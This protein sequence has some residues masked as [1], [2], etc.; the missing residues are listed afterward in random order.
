MLVN[1]KRIWEITQIICNIQEELEEKDIYLS[2]N[3]SDNF[4]Y[5]I[6][7]YIVLNIQDK[8]KWLIS[9]NKN[10][11]LKLKISS[12]AI[13]LK[14]IKSIKINRGLLT[15]LNEAFIINEDKKNDKNSNKT[16]DF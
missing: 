5:F 14:E 16:L 9:N 3:T 4:E 7:N 12:D 1:L 10:L 6:E 2:Y 13:T 11:D 8:D 15:G